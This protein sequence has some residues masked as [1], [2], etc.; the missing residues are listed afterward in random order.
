MT[1]LL[2]SR[3]CGRVSIGASMQKVGCVKIKKTNYVEMKFNL[4]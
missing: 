3:T 4:T 2:F 1:Y